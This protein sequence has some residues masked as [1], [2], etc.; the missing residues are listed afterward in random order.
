M[1]LWIMHTYSRDTDE[2]AHFDSKKRA[3]EYV[4]QEYPDFKRL[5]NHEAWIKTVVKYTWDDIP[6][7]LGYV[8]IEKRD[9]GMW[10]NME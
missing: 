2:Q 8:W 7:G 1:A 3:L 4:Q 5:T 9:N 10:S 6:V